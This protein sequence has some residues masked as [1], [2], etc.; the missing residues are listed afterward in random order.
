[1]DYYPFTKAR[2][3]HHLTGIDLPAPPIVRATNHRRSRPIGLLTSD[4]K[5]SATIVST[6][7]RGGNEP[8]T[9]VCL[10][11]C[12]DLAR[13][14][15][16]PR[17]QLGQWP[18]PIET[19]RFNGR[20][21]LVKRDDRSAFGRGGAK[22]RKLEHVLGHMRACGH[23]EMITVVG[24]ITN[25]GFDLLPALRTQGWSSRIFVQNDPPLPAPARA[26][27]FRGIASEVRFLGR[28]RLGSTCVVLIEWLR[29][30][31]AGRKPFLLLPGAS[32][33]AAIIG[34]ACGFI[35]M[36]QQR[37]A[38]GELLPDKV[39]V[40]V[41]TGTTLAGFLLAE[42]ALRRAG[43]EPI[44]V[45]G[46][47]VY[48]GN[49]A[50]RTRLLLRW[51]E[52]YLGLAHAVDSTVIQIRTEVVG[53]GFGDAGLELEQLCHRV[54]VETN[55]RVDPI[56][57]GKTWSILAR[58][59]ETPSPAGRPT[60]FWHCGYTP[61]W[62][63]LAAATRN[64]RLFASSGART[65]VRTTR[66]RATAIIAAYLAVFYG[67]LPW[68]LWSLG[69]RLDAALALPPLTGIAAAFLG[70]ASLAAGAAVIL[71]STFSLVRLGHGLPISHLPPSR[72]VQRNS[73]G[74]T[75]HPHYVGYNLAFIG[76]GLLQHSWGRAVGSGL[77]LL[78]F[79]LLY[80][81]VFEEPRLLHKFGDDYGV[82]RRSVGI[83]P[84]PSV[85]RAFQTVVRRLRRPLEAAANR[86]VLFRTGPVLWV[87]YGLFA[88]LGAAAMAAGLAWFLLGRGLSGAETWRDVALLTASVALISRTAW[89]VVPGDKPKGSLAELVRR[90]G[91]VS[92]GGYI[93]AFGCALWLGR[94]R[95]IP[96]L[97]M[98]DIVMLT[99]LFASAVSR[100][101]CLAYGCCIGQRASWGL[102]WTDPD[103]WIQRLR[104]GCVA[105]RI[106]TQ[107][108]SSLH[109]GLGGL[110]LVALSWRA[111]SP[112][113]LAAVGGLLY[114]LPRFGVEHLRDEA[115][116]GS[117][118]L[119]AGQFAAA[120]VFILSVALLFLLPDAPAS[121][122]P[123]TLPWRALPGLLAAA[124]TSFAII[125]FIYGFHWKTIGRW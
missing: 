111:T 88:A 43:C 40:S 24:N 33:P 96:P 121:F 57:G 83:L 124:G 69:G 58:D 67:L 61:E 87:T 14:L 15:A 86:L 49:V 19:V 85:A 17:V 18:T 84:L 11:A 120:V 101:G 38:V 25:L 6:P 45:I 42:H 97:R 30:R 1:M 92:W 29:R 91:F 103:S 77:L 65:E 20:A 102:T 63:T 22:T 53:G 52:R 114:A 26:E 4:L 90:V 82:Y 107:V 95:G 94:L 62:K 2:Q 64:A 112:G 93:G 80:A 7:L 12:G 13:I 106:P 32:H 21:V 98:L 117:W 115:R 41:A 100:W 47:Q 31:A 39:F 110:A 73:Y 23:D 116:F 68:F 44:E 75:R 37:L 81:L 16:A 10:P 125:F 34:N 46:V 36:V 59:L 28:S 104:P 72:L 122:W 109:A 74:W 119:T 48:P 8:A 78:G 5:I 108:L 56:F 71:A 54:H 76:C 9:D 118:Q 105:P 60:M 3:V 99:G 27:I 35:E 113:T 50:R 79:W 89:F 51:T 70:A 55:L 123:A 66:L